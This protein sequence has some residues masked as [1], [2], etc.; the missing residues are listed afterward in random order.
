MCW[1]PPIHSACNGIVTF[2]TKDFPEETLSNYQIERLHP[3]DFIFHQFGLNNPGVVIAA[4]RCR[5]R[6]QN[7]PKSVSDYLDTLEKQ[8]LPKSVGELRKYASVL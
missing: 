2:N 6:L 8:G 4:Q 7:P 5:S 3:D 1:L